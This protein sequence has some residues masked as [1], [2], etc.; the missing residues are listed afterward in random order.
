MKSLSSAQLTYRQARAGVSVHVL[1][2]IAAKNRATG[3]IETIGIWS[4][5]DHRVF[6]INSV[7]RT[8]FAA[9]SLLDIGDVISEIGY[10]VRSLDVTL[11]S[12]SNEVIVATSSYDARLAPAEVHIAEFDTE[13]NQLIEVD[14]ER[15]WKG[16]VDEAPSVTANQDDNGQ[17]AGDST[18]TLPL[19]SAA[20]GLTKTLTQ[21]FSDPSQ[22]LRNPADGFFKYADVVS[23]DVWW[24]QNRITSPAAKSRVVNPA[25][26]VL[27]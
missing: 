16:W 12:V 22:R 4:G 15:V 1:L 8:Y 3:E 9:G 6:T 24:G 2:W 13:T 21:K 18:L 19:V 10:D 5:D 23:A 17:P 7:G 26:G 11:S 25:R 20:R 14:L 27:S